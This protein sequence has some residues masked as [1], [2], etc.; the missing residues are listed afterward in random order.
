MTQPHPQT[1]A[2]PAAQVLASP[3][4]TIDEDD[5]QPDDPELS[6]APDLHAL[7]ER[8][9]SWCRTR[10]MYVKPSLPASTLGRLTRKGSGGGTP[11]GP[12]ADCSA[13]LM[14]LRL[15]YLAQ[16]VEALDRSAFELHYY[17]R[18]KNI[19][20]AAA[21]LG[22]SRRHWYRLVCDFRARIYTASREILCINEAA[23]EALPSQVAARA[24]ER[25]HETGAH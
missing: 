25:A 11:G 3:A 2:Q 7:C 8:W 18:V 10:R 6:S 23:R 4:P 16:P 12:D 13:E 5:G 20:H 15:A 22:V 24:A 17:W 9:A 19:K 21:T 14:A 1:T